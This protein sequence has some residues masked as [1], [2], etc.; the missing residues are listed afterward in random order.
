MPSLCT[1]SHILWYTIHGLYMVIIIMWNELAID[2]EELKVTENETYNQRQSNTIICTYITILSILCVVTTTLYRC[3]SSSKECIVKTSL[4]VTH[5][6]IFITTSL[7]L[8]SV[9]DLYDDVI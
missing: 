7:Y 4:L 1:P 3:A 5:M 6:I 9:C 2:A 8:P